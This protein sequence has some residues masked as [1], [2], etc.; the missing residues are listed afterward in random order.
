MSATL[1]YTDGTGAV[2]NTPEEALAQARHDLVQPM[3][4]VPA[5]IIDGDAPVADGES[6]VLEQIFQPCE[7]LACQ[8]HQ[9]APTLHHED[10]A[11]LSE[12]LT[13]R[14]ILQRDLDPDEVKQLEALIGSTRRIA[15]RLRSG[16]PPMAGGAVPAAGFTITWTAVALTA[17]TAKTVAAVL[18]S[19]NTPVDLAEFSVSGDATTGNLLAELAY[20]TAA[21]AGTSTA[22]TALQFRG[23]GQT[24]AATAAIN[25]TAE[26][27]V[28]TVLKRWR[29]P[30]P[31]GPFVIQAP[32]GRELN[33][34][35]TSA[36]SGKQFVLRLTGSGAVSNTDGYLEVEE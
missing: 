23:R 19:A 35:T 8:Y 31:G 26:P 3:N 10:R 24:L 9:E 30:F 18:T 2:Y 13:A 11:I 27:T 34:I 21:T 36:T 14:A 28:L 32:L 16:R 29:F 5:A 6:K 15:E 1:R 20:G 4:L 33:S 25:Y 7:C 12:L 22:F 17:A